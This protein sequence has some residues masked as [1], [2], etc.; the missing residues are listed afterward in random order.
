MARWMDG[1]YSPAGGRSRSRSSSTRARC[2]S[3][4]AWIVSSKGI[5]SSSVASQRES[6]VESQNLVTCHSALVTCHSFLGLERFRDDLT[7]SLLSQTFDS[8][9]RLF[10]LLVADL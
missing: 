6:K 8:P 3:R 9:V 2:S 4:Y 7:P 5:N 1:G 10:D